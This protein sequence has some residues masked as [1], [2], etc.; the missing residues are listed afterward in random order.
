MPLERRSE[1]PSEGDAR[2]CSY[3]VHVAPCAGVGAAV[4]DR[5]S[6]HSVPNGPF[7]EE[8]AWGH[9]AAPQARCR[10]S[11]GRVRK[12][13]AVRRSSAYR[14]RYVIGGGVDRGPR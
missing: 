4:V 14:Y 2:W 1:I 5:R 13:E 11:A 9:P 12:L 3:E 7:G 8:G 10:M 6:A